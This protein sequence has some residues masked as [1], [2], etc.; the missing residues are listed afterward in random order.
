VLDPLQRQPKRRREQ[1]RDDP[2]QQGFEDNVATADFI[3][4][5]PRTVICM[6]NPT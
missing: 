5:E 2:D 1:P 4:A 6:H 3:S